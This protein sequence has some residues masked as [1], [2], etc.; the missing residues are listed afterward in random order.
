MRLQPFLPVFAVLILGLTA[1]DQTP[2]PKFA[3]KSAAPAAEAPVTEM[4]PQATVAQ[5]NCCCCQ[6]PPAQATCPPAS[7]AAKAPAPKATAQRAVHKPRALAATPRRPVRHEGRRYAEAAPV[8]PPAERHYRRYEGPDIQTQGFGAYEHGYQQGYA[9]GGHVQG[10]YVQGG[11]GQAGGYVQVTPP[12]VYAYGGAQV[13]GGYSEHSR[14]SESASG[15]AYGYGQGGGG[16]G[17]CCGP[18]PQRVESAGRDAGGYLTWP[19][20]NAPAPYY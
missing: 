16:G 3:E 15:Y 14:Y 1:C 12:Q 2:K 6:C 8:Q 5:A 20:K 13:Q 7:E 19:G 9:Q 4:A 17:G 11:H 18:R 10:G